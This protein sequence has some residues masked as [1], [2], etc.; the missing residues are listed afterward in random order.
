MS[1][2]AFIDL[3]LNKNHASKIRI[4]SMSLKFILICSPWAFTWSPNKKSSGK[5]RSHYRAIKQC[6]LIPPLPKCMR[7]KVFLVDP[8]VVENRRFN[9]NLCIWFSPYMPVPWKMLP[10]LDKQL[11]PTDGSNCHPQCFSRASHNPHLL[12]PTSVS[13]YNFRKQSCNVWCCQRQVLSLCWN[14][15]LV[16]IPGAGLFTFWNFV[17]KPQYFKDI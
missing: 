11:S 16:P 4:W 15:V 3:F 6:W 13:S 7:P 17:P 12:A 14:L 2:T 1:N 5:H 8:V 10:W 9:V